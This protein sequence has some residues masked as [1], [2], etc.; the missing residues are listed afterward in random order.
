[1]NELPRESHGT[2]LQFLSRR[3]GVRFPHLEAAAQMSRYRRR[4]LLA[5]GA[6]L[7][8]A[9][10]AAVVRLWVQATFVEPGGLSGWLPVE[11]FLRAMVAAP[12]A[13][14]FAMFLPQAT[15]CVLLAAGAAVYCGLQWRRLWPAAV[16]GFL[17]LGGFWYFLLEVAMLAAAD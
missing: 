2:L 5:A 11:S 16:L 12:L 9:Y 17:L 7:L 10:L 15:L 3:G 6:I 13:W 14:I 1:V 8:A 4:L